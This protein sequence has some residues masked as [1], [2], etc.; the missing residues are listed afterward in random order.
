ML[1]KPVFL[2]PL[3]EAKNKK[4]DLFFSIFI[5]QDLLSKFLISTSN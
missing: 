3:R 5:V 4:Y 1:E 2:F